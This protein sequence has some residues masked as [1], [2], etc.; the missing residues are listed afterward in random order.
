MFKYVFVNC[1]QS[2]NKY[3]FS[4]SFFLLYTLFLCS[5]VSNLYNNNCLFNTLICSLFCSQ[6]RT[7]LTEFLLT[8]VFLVLR[9]YCQTFVLDVEGLRPPFSRTLSRVYTRILVYSS[10]LLLL[11][12]LEVVRCIC[13][14]C[15]HCLLL[16][17]AS[18]ISFSHANVV[19]GLHNIF[20]SHCFRFIQQ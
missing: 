20:V 19:A 18:S 2:K 10:C 5:T 16:S 3:V 15:T 7:R 6:Q 9:F 1:K 4:F 13:L 12:Y 17:L 14:L 11:T 8:A